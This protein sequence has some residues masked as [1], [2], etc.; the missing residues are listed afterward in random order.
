MKKYLLLLLLSIVISQLPITVGNAQNVGI[1][2]NTP[3][4]ILDVNGNINVSGTI[5]AKF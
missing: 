1:G 5:K 4:E 3:S 2:T